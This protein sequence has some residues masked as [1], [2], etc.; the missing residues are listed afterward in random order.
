MGGDGYDRLSG[1]KGSDTL[2]GDS[3]GDFL[4][5]NSG[6]DALIGG[7]GKDLLL[8]GSGNDRL[9]GDHG[10]DFLS[11]GADNDT[12]TFNQG[13]GSD[14][15][16]DKSGT[17]TIRFAADVVK[18]EI[19]FLKTATTM[20]IGYGVDDQITMNR[21]A[22]STSGNR[23]ETITLADGSYLTDAD[24]NQLI[25]EM[26]AYAVAEGVSLDSLDNVRQ[27]EQLMTMI[28]DSWNAA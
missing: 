2:F 22:D 28:A 23:I 21:Y 25:Q 15:L 4:K 3:G 27:D 11:G 14:T 24:I 1:G 10:N 17:D 6:D 9:W 8:G 16:Y 13:D 7:A 12:Y 5:G 20:K 26:S 19:A 18:E